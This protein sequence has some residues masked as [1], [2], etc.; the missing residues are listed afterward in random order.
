MWCRHPRRFI[1]AGYAAW[2]TT[3]LTKVRTYGSADSPRRP[4]GLWPAAQTTPTSRGAFYGS[5]DS[6]HAAVYDAAATTTYR[7]N[8]LYGPGPV[9]GPCGTGYA[10]GAVD[11]RHGQTGGG[12]AGG[13]CWRACKASRTAVSS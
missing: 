10:T 5:Y 11:L 3:S 1:P 2:D 4:R 13:R 7:T 12:V 8:I 6:P 9:L